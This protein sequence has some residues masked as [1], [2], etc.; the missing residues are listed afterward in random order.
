M[1]N[2]SWQEPFGM[3]AIEGLSNKMVVVGSDVG[4]L[5]EI[6]KNKGILISEID[7]RKLTLKLRDLL[8]SSVEIK[9]YQNLAWD[10]YSFDQKNISSLQDNMRREIFAKFNNS[11]D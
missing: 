4:G 11:S 7:S 10:N 2:F 1:E 9:K 6:I 5:S 3:T 8:K